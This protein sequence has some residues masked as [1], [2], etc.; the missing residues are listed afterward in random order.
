MESPSGSLNPP[1]SR[2]RPIQH[3]LCILALWVTRGL[4]EGLIHFFIPS[5][6]DDRP[7]MC[8]SPLARTIKGRP[9]IKMAYSERRHPSLTT[10]SKRGTKALHNGSLARGKSRGE[11]ILICHMRLDLERSGCCWCQ[12][13]RASI[14]QLS[15]SIR[16]PHVISPHTPFV[17]GAA[18]T[19]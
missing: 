9:K 19:P 10:S 15:S 5:T 11:L 17:N 7:G 12:G 13:D 14:Y 4:S 16:P 2:V 18:G 1:L 8:S 3:Q 6:Q